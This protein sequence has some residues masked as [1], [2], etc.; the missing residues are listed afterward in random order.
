MTP[1]QQKLAAGVG[2]LVLLCAGAAG[3]R[4]GVRAAERWQNM[5]PVA[6][7]D[8]VPAFA[9][10]LLDGGRISDTDLPGKPSLMV[11]WATWCGV[12][13]AEMPSLNALQ[14]KYGD[15]VNFVAVNHEGSG[16]RQARATV[17]SFMEH[18]PVALPVAIDDGR[19]SRAFRVRALPH[20]VLLDRE[21]NIQHVHQ[22]IVGQGTLEDELNGLL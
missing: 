7:G 13:R 21:G 14:E 20:V 2:A 19:T 8:E 10:S 5:G 3:A 22:G 1:L 12:C 17:R 6:S 9:M 11:F 15:R 4:D 16:P 18:N